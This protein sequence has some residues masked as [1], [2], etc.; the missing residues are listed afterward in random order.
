MAARDP[1][2]VERTMKELRGHFARGGSVVEFCRQSG[3]KDGTLYRWMKDAGITPPSS[4]PKRDRA[5]KGFRRFDSNW[6]HSP[7]EVSF[8]VGGVTISCEAGNV[9]TILEALTNVGN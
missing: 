1:E 8:K 7:D 2:K 9:R 5:T 3:I 4:L 6:T